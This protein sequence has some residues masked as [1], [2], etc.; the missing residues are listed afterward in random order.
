[1]WRP[2]LVKHSL[3]WT[4]ATFAS[5]QIIESIAMTQSPQFL[6]AKQAGW[7]VPA[8]LNCSLGPVVEQITQREKKKKKISD[9][10]CVYAQDR[11]LPRLAPVEQDGNRCCCVSGVWPGHRIWNDCE[12]MVLMMRLQRFSTRYPELLA[13]SQTAEIPSVHIIPL[14]LSPGD[15]TYSVMHVCV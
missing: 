13:R 15:S 1:M 12:L 14:H 3:C 5:P 6:A 2:S 7:C 11:V 8:G 4:L 10:Y 9:N